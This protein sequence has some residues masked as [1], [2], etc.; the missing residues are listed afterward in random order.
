MK[1]TDDERKLEALRAMYSEVG[2]AGKEAWKAAPAKLDGHNLTILGHPVMEDWEH[3]YMQRLA[4]V[5]TSNG[6]HVLEIGF[7][8]GISAG[9]IQ[10]AENLVRHTIIEANRD[11]AKLG[12]AFAKEAKREVHILEGLWEEL[13]DKI[14]DNSLDGILHDAYPLD[15]SEVMGQAHFAKTA[16]KKLRPG[17]V[18]TYFSDEIHRFRPDH[19]KKLLDAGFKRENI[20]GE[21]VPVTPPADCRYWNGPSIL[22]PRL[23]K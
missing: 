22:A 14:P 3:P 10:K 8:L 18:F 4:E 20:S 1:L 11:I 17:G 7:G 2:F 12:H 5:A 6:G 23:I 16:Y 13:I 15:E 19:L 21:V 9:Y